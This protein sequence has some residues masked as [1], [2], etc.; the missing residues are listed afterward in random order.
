MYC[1]ELKNDMDSK[2]PLCGNIHAKDN[3]NVIVFN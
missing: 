1:G 3:C 2:C